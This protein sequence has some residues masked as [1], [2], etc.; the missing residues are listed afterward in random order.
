MIEF[1]LDIL[2]SIASAVVI[3][4]SG[5]AYKKLKNFHGEHE[6]LVSHLKES[7]NLKAEVQELKELQESQNAALRE[8][9]GKMLDDAHKLLVAQGYASPAEKAAIERLYKA[10]H[11]L[12]GNGTR[13]ALYEDV[14]TMNS[15]PTAKE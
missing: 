11:G 5:V 9:L 4:V 10:Y 1:I 8:V 12:G 7:E 2:P 15:Y 6:D 14:L 3:G 13:T